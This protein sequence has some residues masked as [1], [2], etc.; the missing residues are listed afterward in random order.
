[1]AVELRDLTPECWSDLQFDLDR[2]LDR[3]LQLLRET[4]RALN[5]RASKSKPRY[6][7][8]KLK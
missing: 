8:H 2:D 4:D 3:W 6:E 1:L 5:S 7:Q